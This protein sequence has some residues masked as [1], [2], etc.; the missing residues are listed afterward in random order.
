MAVS[1]PPNDR[2]AERIVLG[3]ALLNPAVITAVDLNPDDFYHPAHTLLW[4]QLCDTYAAGDPTEPAAM[5]ARLVDAGLI[6]RVGGAAYVASL[7]NAVPTVAN[8]PHYAAR[9]RELS[10]RRHLVVVRDRIDEMARTGTDADATEAMVRE[11]IGQNAASTWPQ[12]EPL[13]GQHSALPAFP[14]DA[15]PAWLAEHVNAVAEFNQVPADLPACLALACLST[16][17]GGKVLL[18][19]RRGWKEP[20]NIFTVVAMPP[21]TR[22]TPVF[23]AM[24]R[25]IKQ[26]E[27]Q[28]KELIKPR[29]IE[30]RT[31][32]KAAQAA[33]DRAAGK[34]QPDSDDETMAEA[35]GAAMAAEQITIPAEPELIADDIT[36]E[37]A[38]SIMAEQGGRLAVLAPE[39][40]IIGTIAGRYSGTPNFDVFLRGHGGDD[41]KVG[42]QSRNKEELER[43]ALT[44]GLCLQPAVLRELHRI[45][46]ASDKGLLG[47]IL[48]SLPPDNVG[49]RD[50][51]PPTVPE[52]VASRYD[53]EIRA[54]TI[55]LADLEEAATVP[56]SADA[57]AIITDLIA[58][59]ER[60][61]R[62]NA[63]WA[64]IRE[65]GNK[66]VGSVI[67]RIAGLLHVA[68]HLRDGWQQPITVVT[69]R[70]A[71]HIGQYFAAHALAAFDAMGTDPMTGHAQAALSWL[72]RTKPHQFSK[73]EM[74]TAIYRGRFTKADELDPVLDLLE[75]HGYIRRLPAPERRGPGRKPSPRFLTHPRIARPPLRAVPDPKTSGAAP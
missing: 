59:T 3:A 24:V 67:A 44:L 53:T 1:E 40:G 64:H 7:V 75:Q 30:A 48:Y 6:N 26:A 45:P 33:A 61:L 41:L 22:K 74:W 56:F 17:A 68:E 4:E 10:R 14:V 55:S 65:W 39:G 29:I 47:R 69:L 16:A 38:A 35:V 63:E 37:M 70:R 50:P 31:A 20:V 18:E 60:K 58:A 42:R 49:F 62:P 8:A 71:I 5:V 32:L 13:H 19:P 73:R 21:G 54:L 34:V 72:E 28:L 66:F 43:A 11:L 36:P 46:G 25:P 57:S 51:N 9:V 15:L 2:Q 23:R 52:S 27:K 12:P